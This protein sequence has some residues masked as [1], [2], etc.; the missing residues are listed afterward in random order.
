MPARAK[1][2][3]IIRRWRERHAL[4]EENEGTHHEN[5]KSGIDTARRVVGPAD[6]QLSDPL[7]RILMAAD[8]VDPVQLER[9]LTGI[10][11]HAAPHVSSALGNICGCT[12]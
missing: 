10:A 9:M 1:A 11:H 3:S 4:V 6:P 8:K 12:A 2:S 7:I 5:I